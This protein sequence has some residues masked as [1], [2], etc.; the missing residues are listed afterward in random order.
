MLKNRKVRQKKIKEA[1]STKNR[2]QS[3][4]SEDFGSNRRSKYLTASDK[5]IDATE[6]VY[7]VRAETENV[8]FDLNEHSNEEEVIEPQLKNGSGEVDK[9]IDERGNATKSMMLYECPKCGKKYAK[10]HYAKIHCRVK[11]SWICEI[12]GKEIKEKCNVKRHMKRCLKKQRKESVV[13]QAR[14]FH[15]GEC[16]QQFPNS[17]N[18]TRHSRV[19]HNTDPVGCL[20]CPVADCSFSTDRKQQMT[21]HNTMAHSTRNKKCEVCEFMCCS[22][23]GLRK[24]RLTI[25]GLECQS[26]GKLFSTEN[27]LTAH[28]KKHPEIVTSGAGQIVVTRKIGEHASTY[29]RRVEDD[30]QSDNSYGD[31]EHSEI[32]NGDKSETSSLVE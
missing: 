32:N 26:C 4:N 21:R 25:H 7:E 18:L 12:C 31:D 22:E 5:G 15:C 19:A 6:E 17:F 24:H 23:S 13:K 14:I 1:A 9:N 27:K 2:Q 20:K 11:P 3:L 8:L 29:C 30:E 28:M 10:K 16:G